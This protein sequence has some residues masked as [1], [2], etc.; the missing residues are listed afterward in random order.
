VSGYL[1]CLPQ[2]MDTFSNIL[3]VKE[4]GAPL[5]QLAHK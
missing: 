1:I 5:S 3:F 4:L 2:G